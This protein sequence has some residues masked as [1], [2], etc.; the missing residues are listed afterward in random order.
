MVLGRNVDVDSSGAAAEPS[1]F[2]ELQQLADAAVSE[3]THAAA[4]RE[5]ITAGEQLQVTPR[6]REMFALH[7]EAS[8]HNHYGPSETHVVTALTLQ[9]DP[10]EWPALPAIGRPIANT[11]ILILDSH[12]AP[13][14]VGIPGELL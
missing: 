7:P 10:N 9:G 12:M 14:P 6:V 13:V 2:V 8:L 1:R 11:S 5:V 4:L 3:G